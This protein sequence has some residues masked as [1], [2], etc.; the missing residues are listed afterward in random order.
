M[1]DIAVICTRNRL[2]DLERALDSVYSQE[3]R[4]DQT[5]VVDSSD[6]SES[7]EMMRQMARERGWDSLTYLRSARGLTLQRNV[8]LEW[9]RDSGHLDVVHFFDDDVTLDPDY[10]MHIV[11]TFELMDWVVGA[12]G[13]IYGSVRGAPS[14]LARVFL[15]DASKPGAVLKSGYNI[16]AF[17]T[18]D[19]IPVDWMPG[20]GMSYRVAALDGLTFDESRT[21]YALGEDVDFGLKAAARGALLH[22]AEAK[23]VHH[24]SP[25]NRH[26]RPKLAE[27]GV[28]NR[29]Q[30]A[31]DH[32]QRVKK[33][34]VLYSAFGEMLV[35][36]VRGILKLKRLQIECGIA[37]A[38]GILQI[39]RS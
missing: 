32:P 14:F 10:C 24:L 11:R 16:G 26:T 17:E 36:F 4:P 2:H 9:I 35:Y 12:G 29:W 5:L 20:C 23:L 19:T 1:R 13:A 31:V 15:R 6:G 34:L 30:L 25:V 33:S 39:A 18:P 28:L 38:K 7:E 22:V 3:R 27:A 8:A 21:G 37:V